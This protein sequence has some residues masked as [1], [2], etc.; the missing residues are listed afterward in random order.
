[1]MGQK[2]SNWKQ[3]DKSKKGKGAFCKQ[4]DLF[5]LKKS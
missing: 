2:E 1:M 4:T 3:A 5:A